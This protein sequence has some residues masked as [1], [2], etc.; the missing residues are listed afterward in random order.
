MKTR[1]CFLSTYNIYLPSLTN[2]YYMFMFAYINVYILQSA[3]D[4]GKWTMLKETEIKCRY[5]YKVFIWLKGAKSDSKKVETMKMHE[6]I[7]KFSKQIFKTDIEI[8]ISVQLV[9]VWILCYWKQKLSNFHEVTCQL[10][11]IVI[12]YAPIVM[13][14]CNCILNSGSLVFF[15]KQTIITL[16]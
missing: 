5:G 7:Y 9:Y 15:V 3:P 14:K 11:S 12:N 10:A 4:V 8:S 6:I 13:W 2:G 16:Y 1:K